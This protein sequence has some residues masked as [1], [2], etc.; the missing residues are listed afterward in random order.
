MPDDPDNC[1]LIANP[2]Q[3]DLDG[4]GVGD[5][6]DSDIDGDGMPAVLTRSGQPSDPVRSPRSV[7][8]T[9][10]DERLCCFRP[11]NAEYSA[12]A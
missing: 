2:D 7:P 9:P 3:A 8:R 6:C 10:R 12:T 11:I 4:D 1:P 5:A